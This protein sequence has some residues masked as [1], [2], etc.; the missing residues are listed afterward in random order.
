MLRINYQIVI[1]YL[2]FLIGTLTLFSCKK[3]ESA[4]K[5]DPPIKKPEELPTLAVVRTWLV[6]KE[7]TEQTAALFYNLKKVSKTKVLFG[8][9]ADT[10]QGFGWNDANGTSDVKGVTGAYPAVYGSDFLFIASFQRNSWF[11]NQARITK[12]QVIAAYK[13]GGVST[14]CWHYWN[15]VSSV[16]ASSGNEGSNGAF[17]WNDSHVKAVDKILPG[18]SHHEVYKKSLKI[19]AD[20]AKSLNSDGVLVPVI[21]RPFHEFDGD[22]FW[23]GK[24]HC[25][26]QEYKALYQFTVTYLRDEL[27]VRNF[28][29]AFSPDNG[30]ISETQYL[31]R[32]PGD[33]YVDLVGTDNYWDLRENGA[34]IA[35]ASNKLKIV[36]DYAIR[37]NK[38]A[39]FTETGLNLKESNKTNWY[40]QTLLKVL[41]QQKLE[42]AYV[43]TWANNSGS[44]F[45]PYPN[46]LAANDFITFKNDPYILFGDKIPEMYKI[47]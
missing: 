1:Y 20:F 25:T 43:L 12:E 42:L 15:P 26:T 17:Y 37:K 3:S 36:S 40:T 32:Y 13:R 27:K 2:I 14:F 22:W 39:A 19:V 6:D 9:Q 44:Y 16:L 23:W 34:D 18:G 31:E 29:Y 33:D 5:E 10:E 45:V 41:K 30:F 47:R 7:A 11:D 21:F 4:E 8:H 46:H 28:L 38:L 35:L 24:A